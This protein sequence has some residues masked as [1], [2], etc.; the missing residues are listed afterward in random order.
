M[1]LRNLRRTMLGGFRHSAVYP[2][3]DNFKDVANFRQSASMG[4]LAGTR[5]TL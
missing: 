3:L 5:A 4:P 2:C 1:T